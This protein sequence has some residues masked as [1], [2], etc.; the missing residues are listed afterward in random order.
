MAPVEYSVP[1]GA[2]AVAVVE[3]FGGETMGI[4]RQDDEEAKTLL[5]VLF[6]GAQ[7]EQAEEESPDEP[8]N[9]VT[10]EMIDEDE[11]VVEPSEKK[12]NG[13]DLPIMM[14]V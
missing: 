10:D 12:R 13:S 8:S 9:D 14:S 11:E 7:H 3:V 6:R 5:T 1:V 4:G 2:A